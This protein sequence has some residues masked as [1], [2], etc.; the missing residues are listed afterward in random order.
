ML[1]G[2]EVAVDQ[3]RL[4]CVAWLTGKARTT[5]STVQGTPVDSPDSICHSHIRYFITHFFTAKIHRTHAILEGR[6]FV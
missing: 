6:E 1:H 3:G 5:L 4:K 2:A